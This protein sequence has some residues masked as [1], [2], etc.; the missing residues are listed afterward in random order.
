[1][2]DAIENKLIDTK[3][4]MRFTTKDVKGENKKRKTSLRAKAEK[5]LEHL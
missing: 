3:S 2:E 1:M 4:L 5:A